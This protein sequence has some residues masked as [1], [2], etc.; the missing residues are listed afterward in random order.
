MHCDAPRNEGESSI[1]T[2]IAGCTGSL[3]LEVQD[4]LS[5]F[6]IS[7]SDL[8]TILLWAVGSASARAADESGR[9]GRGQRTQEVGIL[10]VPLGIL[11]GHP[12]QQSARAALLA[13][14]V[15]PPAALRALHVREYVAIECASYSASNARPD[16]TQRHFLTSR[17]RR[18][19]W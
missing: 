6:A 5:I 18:P 10:R 8:R 13:K 4:M 12:H 15:P 9:T 7:K 11:A 1:V 16:G 17:Y 14:L 19:S 3:A 2:V